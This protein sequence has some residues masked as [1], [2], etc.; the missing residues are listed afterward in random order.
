MGNQTKVEQNTNNENNDTKETQ[1]ALLSTPQRMIRKKAVSLNHSEKLCTKKSKRKRMLH[2]EC[3]SEHLSTSLS[4]KLTKV[5][6]EKKAKSASS[7]SS[8]TTVSPSSPSSQEPI[9]RLN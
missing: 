1:N 4:P 7:S 5:N 3:Y 6:N 9:T 8:V 2:D